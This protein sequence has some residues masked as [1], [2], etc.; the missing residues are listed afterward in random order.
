MKKCP[1]CAEEILDEA[2]KCKHCGE[3]LEKKAFEHLTHEEE[4]TTIDFSKE[5]EYY[6]KILTE[7]DA[8]NGKYLSKWNWAAFFFGAL[9]YLYKGMWAGTVLRSLMKI[10]PRPFRS[11][12]TAVLCT[13]SWKTYSGVPYLTSAC[14][15]I[16]TARATPAQKPCVLARN[17]CIEPLNVIR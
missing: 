16:S 2:V 4:K 8:N 5:T 13:I 9:W 11:L 1:F 6:Q 3:V 14:S 10:M 7:I 15:T 17:I 12:T